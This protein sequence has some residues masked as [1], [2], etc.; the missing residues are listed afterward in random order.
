MV[1]FAIMRCL[2]E[3]KMEVP[4]GAVNSL[5]KESVDEALLIFF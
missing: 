1:M 3:L 2:S 4:V 5:I